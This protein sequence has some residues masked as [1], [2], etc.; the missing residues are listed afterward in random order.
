MKQGS[1]LPS[2]GDASFGKTFLSIR[3]LARYARF[4][5]QKV[6][7]VAPSYRQA[8]QIVW[9]ELKEKLYAVRWIKKVNESDLTV[10][11]VNNSTISLRGAENYDSLRGVGLNFLVMD[12][13]TM[14]NKKAWQEVLRPT[15]SDTGGHALFISTPS[16]KGNWGYDLY[17]Q[18]LLDPKNWA[19]WQYTSLEGGRIPEEEIEAARMDLDER[20][21]KQEYLASF[22]T[23]SGTIYYAF[24]RNLNNSTLTDIDTS[25]LYV[26][27]DQ[28]IDPM[29]AVIAVRLGNDLHIID[30]IQIYGSNTDEMCDEI[31]LR[32]PNSKIF[33]YPD[34]S[35]SAR[36]TSSAGRTDHM[37]Y[38]NAGFL[39]KSPRGHDPVRDRINA[40]NS[41]LC[42]GD[43]ARHLFVNQKCKH[44]IKGLERQTYKEGTQQPD[45]SSGLD[46]QMDAMGYMVAYIF[47]I[48][49]KSA[50]VAP[51]RW[52]HNIV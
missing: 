19:S 48:K 42:S 12:E 41:R 51:S 49:K 24:D 9:S 13:F 7:Y 52:G 16:G 50:I 15:L 21:F 23:Y 22:E 34:P 47:P 32:Y 37:I 46:H 5:K 10:T 28:N 6:F 30:E 2:A 39:V 1:K 44:T 40:V 3:E 31:K 35:G 4:P 11:L 14:I 36:K 17:N 25:V 29:S 8:K 43:G 18:P 27:L 20:T 38:A 45:K 26:G 33:A